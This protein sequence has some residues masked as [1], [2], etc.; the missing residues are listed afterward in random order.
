MNS[1]MTCEISSKKNKHE[2]WKELRCVHHVSVPRGDDT[3]VQQNNNSPQIN[4]QPSIF[5]PFVSSP[6][7]LSFCF[8]KLKATKN[9][10]TISNHKPVKP[11]FKRTKSFQNPFPCSFCFGLQPRVPTTV[12]LSQSNFVQDPFWLNSCYQ[13]ASAF[14]VPAL[15]LSSESS[16]SEWNN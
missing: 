11:T 6:F 10:W 2:L 5:P 16:E 7:F 8:Q 3:H 15:G 1:A 4:F 9:S 13:V 12:S 14:L